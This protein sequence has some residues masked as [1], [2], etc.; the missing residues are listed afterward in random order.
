V[1]LVNFLTLSLILTIG[2]LLTFAGR[3]LFD[4]NRGTEAEALLA[5]DFISALDLIEVSEGENSYQLVRTPSA[6]RWQIEV[7][8]QHPMPVDTELL[9]DFFQELRLATVR[10]VEVAA[11]ESLGF[12]T[13][14]ESV[15]FRAGTELLE[16]HFGR[17]NP[18]TEARYI[19]RDQQNTPYL[20][21]GA[22]ADSMR[23][24]ATD[25]IEH[26]PFI[27]MSPEEV[28]SIRSTNPTWPFV[29]ERAPG[30]SFIASEEQD[31]LLEQSIMTRGMRRLARVV[32]E[33]EIEYKPNYIPHEPLLTIEARTKTYFVERSSESDL[34]LLSI[35]GEPWRYPV[36][37]GMLSDL[38]REKLYYR[39]RKP[40]RAV[41]FVEDEEKHKT[42]LLQALEVQL[43]VEKLPTN[44]QPVARV[45]AASREGN[46]EVLVL[47]GVEGDAEL[48]ERS[49]ATPA[50]VEAQTLQPRYVKLHLPQEEFFAVVSA[51]TA[52]R[53]IAVQS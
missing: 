7:E 39:N 26:T 52:S 50:H 45:T 37:R 30:E 20:M 10:A 4:I 35:E 48:A 42:E 12:E 46:I 34:L 41:Q 5:P 51:E 32:V 24:K 15:R 9:E 21:S 13:E 49:L 27:S 18:V 44:Q 19:Q 22:L 3:S 2:L 43:F 1:K 28:S 14:Q 25:W 16:V 17:V 6:S 23:R 47:G 36:E 8:E 31:F 53:L 11:E 33:E 38:L 40:L 29:F